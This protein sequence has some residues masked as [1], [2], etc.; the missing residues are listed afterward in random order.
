MKHEMKLREEPFSMMAEGKKTVELRLYDEKRR[1]IEVGDE[2]CFRHASDEARTLTRYVV[3]LHLYP[4]FAALYAALPLSA[5]GYTA[6]TAASASAKDMRC[7]YTEEDEKRWGV[8]GIELTEDEDVRPYLSE[9]ELF[10]YVSREVFRKY[11][12]AFRALAKL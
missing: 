5:L 8:V 12:G 9:R 2:I 6:E 10:D 1:A 7:Y 11:D 3:R 4:S